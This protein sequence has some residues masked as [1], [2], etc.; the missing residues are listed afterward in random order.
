MNEYDK[1]QAIIEYL[2]QRFP[3]GNTPHHMLGRLLE[4]T[5]ELA[6]QVHHFEGDGIK[7]DKLGEPDKKKFAK[8][9]QDVV[10]ILVEITEYY[11][12][13]KEIQ[14]SIEDSYKKISGN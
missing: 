4:E 1:L 10:R 12:L 14:D 11:G 7:K 9:V 3:K 13:K 6:E 5:G 8:E 2:K